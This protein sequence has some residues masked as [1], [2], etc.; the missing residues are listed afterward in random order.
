M[1]NI[2]C[3]HRAVVLGLAPKLIMA[4][5][6]KRIGLILQDQEAAA[7]ILVRSGGDG[8]ARSYLKFKPDGSFHENILPSTEELWAYSDVDGAILTV[9]EKYMVQA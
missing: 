4:R 6:E 3:V 8:A 9:V 2:V 5:N 7:V 1:A